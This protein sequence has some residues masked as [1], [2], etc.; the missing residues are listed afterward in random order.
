[1]LAGVAVAVLLLAGAGAALWWLNRP[2]KQEAPPDATEAA[3]YEVP[4]PARADVPDWDL[5]TRD[6]TLPT[7]CVTMRLQINA[8]GDGKVEAKIQYPAEDYRSLKKMLSQRHRVQGPDGKPKIE[9]REPKIET[10]LRYLE[11][12]RAT[13]KVE[14]LGGALDDAGSTIRLRY[15]HRGCSRLGEEGWVSEIDA[16]REVT[17]KVVSQTGQTVLLEARQKEGGMLV[18]SRL[19]VTLPA[20]ASDVVL[21]K[22]GRT[23]LCYRAPVPA[24]TVRNPARPVLELEV[25]PQLMAALYKL[26]GDRKWDTLW[27]ARSVFRN[28]SAETLTDLRVRFR[29]VGYSEW[30]GWERCAKVLPGQTIVD[31]FHPVLDPKVRE[32]RT[33]TPADIAVEYS[34]TRPD[35]TRVSDSQTERTKILGI[36]AGAWSNLELDEH[37]SWYEHFKDADLVI[38]AFVTPNDPIVLELGGQ[39]SKVAGGGG[40]ALGDKEALQYL[41]ALY[42]VFR[43]NISYETTGGDEV[44]GLYHQTLKYGRDV[45][46][47]KSGTCVN[48]AILYASACEAAGLDAYVCV[49]PGHA[50]P[51]V[52]LP[53]SKQVLWVETTGCGGG[54][55]ESSC[56]FARALGIAE[57]TH[58]KVQAL[59]LFREVDIPEMRRRGVT[60]PDLPDLG[61]QSLKDWG[62]DIRPLPSLLPSLLKKD[63]PAPPPPGPAPPADVGST[64]VGVWAM[65][66]T[67]DGARSAGGVA[68]FHGSGVMKISA[69][70][71]KLLE[72]RYG[73]RDGKLWVEGPAGGDREEV[74]LAWASKDSF[75]FASEGITLAFSRQPIKARVERVWYGFDVTRDG[76]L[77]VDVHTHLSARNAPGLPLRVCVEFTDKAGRPLKAKSKAYSTVEGNMVAYGDLTPA[78]PA[79]DN[80]DFVVFVPYDEITTDPGR[81]ELKL[82]VGVWCPRDRNHVA[83]KSGSG[84]MVLTR[85]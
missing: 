5:I 32:L 65:R 18:V 43:A 62:I 48:L 12:D 34:Y 72:G 42:N 51:G 53:K 64:L 56:D 84:Q 8:L 17:Y 37:S 66:A 44:D 40:A 80:P 85:K 15:T 50:F 55:P 41:E 25:R 58:K 6:P 46:R 26:Y 54:T 60:P 16:N 14:G 68:V 22:R 31:A 1:V 33:T 81:H 78:G 35:G 73:L 70:E 20:G 74:A 10:V 39:A 59:G 61:K 27:A 49:I 3:V 82:W 38:A 9:L 67:K 21:K 79:V 71:K 29:L 36:T 7:A 28:N 57:Q 11:L 76:R 30:G 75:S 77:G 83:E 4:W 47:T 13:A 2:A 63:R 69:G 52:R 24:V 45:L 19:L 23:D